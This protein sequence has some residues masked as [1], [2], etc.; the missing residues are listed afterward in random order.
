MRA[1][2]AAR[3][4]WLAPLDGDDAWLPNRLERMLSERGAE[5]ADAIS[6]DLYPVDGWPD[7]VA[8]PAASLAG[9]AEDLG[10][11]RAGS[12][13][14]TW[15][16]ITSASSSRSCAARSWSATTWGFP[17][18]VWPMTSTCT[19]RC[20]WRV[21]VA[22]VPGACACL[23]DPRLVTTSH[24]GPNYSKI[25]PTTPSRAWSERDPALQAEFLRFVMD[26]RASFC[27]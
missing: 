21:P 10:H 17:M 11:H 1:H 2:A 26:E 22:S 5:H 8:L 12:T 15:S 18:L 27:W 9:P 23:H 7:R 13:H 3:G 24:M 14:A 4:E 6:D 25:T 20:F 16:A 19:W